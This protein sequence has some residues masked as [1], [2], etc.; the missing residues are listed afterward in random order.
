MIAEEP[1]WW[2]PFGIRRDDS[3]LVVDWCDLGGN[4]LDE[5]MFDQ[6]VRQRLRDHPDA[7][8][9]TS[10]HQLTA[11]APSPEPA[12]FVFHMSRCGSTLVSR[13]LN[14][15]SHAFALSEP[16][17]VNTAL[18]RERSGD[19]G[20]LSGVIGAL[21]TSHGTARRGFVKFPA[22]GIVDHALIR[23]AFPTTPAI[24]VYR[25]PVEVLV[26]LVGSSAERL[27]PGL[28][29]SGLLDDDPRQTGDRMRP[30]EFW[31]RVIGRQ[32][33]A[34]LAANA[35]TALRFVN[36]NELPTAMWEHIAKFFGLGLTEDDLARMRAVSRRSAKNPGQA[37]RSDGES[38]RNAATPEIEDAAEQFV[39]PHYEEL[40]RI[41][42]ATAESSPSRGAAT[43]T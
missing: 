2:V 20:M 4:A 1:S 37:F 29:G 7:R 6:S 26:S 16:A 31:A 33:A 34:A 19:H 30:A 28:A 17:V 15:V 35:Q 21:T 27:P 43:S 3:G 42:G 8:R 10:L 14:A 36:Y 41:R 22:R 24:F 5:P 13:L 12:G 25:E 11:A 9:T 40:E 38:K 32:C 39:R 18:E 23:R